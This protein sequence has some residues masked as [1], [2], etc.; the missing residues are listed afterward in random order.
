MGMGVQQK[1]WVVVED[2]A[3][4]SGVTSDCIEVQAHDSVGASGLGCSLI[5]REVVEDV[6]ES[7][8]VSGVCMGAGLQREYWLVVEDIADSSG[9]TTHQCMEVQ[10]HE[11][12]GAWR[13]GCMDVLN[14][15]IWESFCCTR[16]EV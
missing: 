8:G 15:T 2:V 12:T 10:M 11:G 1:Y 9:V 16:I 3:E 4:T 7:S 6:A 14:T 5:Y 13:W